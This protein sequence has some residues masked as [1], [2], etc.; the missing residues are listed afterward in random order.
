MSSRKTDIR[1]TA[2]TEI[3]H[4]LT[5]KLNTY[6]VFPDIAEKICA[7]LQKSL[8]A[9]DFKD[10]I[11][12]ETLALKLTTHIQAVNQDKHLLVR[13]HP[14]LLPDQD[15]AMV[16]NQAWLE[17]RRQE[18]EL[19]NYGLH[20]V[21]RLPGNVGYLEIR[22]FYNSSW[23]GDTAVAAMTFLANTNGLIFD[24]RECRGGDSDTIALIYSYLVGDERVQLTSLYWRDEDVTLEYWT[25]PYVPGK[26]FGDKPVYVLTGKDTFSGGE[27]FAYDLQAHQRA[28]LV[29][30]ITRGGAHPGTNYRLHAH[31]DV[32]IPNG[33]AINPITGENWE[34]NGVTPDIQIPQE[35]AL[36]MA[37]RMALQSIIANLDKT[38]SRPL[39][40]LKEEARTALKEPEAQVNKKS[41]AR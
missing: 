1:A 16:E 21:E 31:F 25:L 20:K 2:Q 29:G 6:Y 23:A 5:D 35:Q 15:G 24:L 7:R 12:G 34:G 28:I 39:T 10:S 27:A 11:D 40:L 17:E 14:E 41:F 9:G 26:R 33:R 19:D 4:N 13:W 38:K 22:E 36:D 3:V 30:E 37:Y 18:A 8:E 32:F